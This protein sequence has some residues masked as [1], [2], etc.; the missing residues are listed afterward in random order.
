MLKITLLLLVTLLSACSNQDIY[1]AIQHS[2]QHECNKE[3]P[4]IREDCL[5]RN[6]KPYSKYTQEREAILNE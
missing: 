6:Q 2:N 1:E 5:A 3:L 4:S